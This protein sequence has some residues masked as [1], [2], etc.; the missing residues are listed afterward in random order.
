MRD[1]GAHVCVHGDHR[2]TVA[3][4]LQ[5]LSTWNV[6]TGLLTDLGLFLVAGLA[7]F[8]EPRDLPVC[9]SPALGLHP[10]HPALFVVCFVAVFSMGQGD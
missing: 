10:P 7:V 4:A 8:Y 2:A 5:L 9:A 1:L 6:E 3:V